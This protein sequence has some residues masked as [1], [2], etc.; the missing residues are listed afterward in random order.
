M[1]AP[2]YADEITVSLPRLHRG[3][4]RI[5]REIA[6]RDAR[7]AVI[8][9]GRRWGKTTDGVEWLAD[10]ALSGE[11]CAWMAPSYKLLGEAWREL[12]TRLRPAAAR[13]SEQD[14]RIELL[15][16]GVI[17]CW[18]LDGPDPAR[19]RKYK[20]VVI[21][22]AGIVRD[23]L[24]VWQQAIRPTLVDLHGAARIYGTPKGRTHGFVTLFAKGTSGEDGWVAFRAPTTDNPYIPAS[25]IAI[26]KRELPAGVFAQEFEGVPADDGGNPFGLDAITACVAPLSSAQPVVWGWDFARAQDWTVGIGLDEHGQVC[27]FERWQAVPWGET[28]QK[29]AQLTGRIP[30]TGDATGIGDVIVEDLRRMSVPMTG[31]PFTPKSKQMLMERLAT[32]IQAGEIGIPDGVLRTELETF[33]FEYTAHGVRYSA[34]D[35]LHDDCVMALALAVRTFDLHG[36][37]WRAR[38]PQRFQRNDPRIVVERQ[39]RAMPIDWTTGKPK[40]RPRAEDELSRIF[41]EAQGPITQRVPASH[42]THQRVVVRR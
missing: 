23:L 30:A 4:E 3:Q 37:L 13:V 6:E 38:D 11:P 9:C 5:R 14:H 24:D 34:P 26:A 20:R 10:G 31:L 39:D 22:E 17:E 21:D 40:P 42:L 41:D 36:Y 28:K 27:R 33:T 19:G 16:G 29:V 8:M 1:T 18:T 35:G 25:E 12:S 2:A 15:G 32:V 7:F